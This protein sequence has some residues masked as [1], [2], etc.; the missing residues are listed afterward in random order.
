MVKKLKGK[1]KKIQRKI[2]VPLTSF[3]L[4][5]IF[6]FFVNW[7]LSF[8]FLFIRSSAS[9]S[10]NVQSSIR[11]EFPMYGKF[12]NIFVVSVVD[13]RWNFFLQFFIGSINTLRNYKSS[14][15]T[16]IVA[17]SSIAALAAAAAIRGSTIE[18]KKATVDMMGLPDLLNGTG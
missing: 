17:N 6:H 15:L 10:T 1:G 4:R 14:K 7:G 16:L 2:S 8:F 9:N 5:N 11:Y 13:A 3:L 18:A 12:F